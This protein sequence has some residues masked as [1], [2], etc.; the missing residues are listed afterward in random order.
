MRAKAR[1]IGMLTFCIALVAAASARATEEVTD[2]NGKKIHLEE[3]DV[4]SHGL[5]IHYY[6]VGEGPLVFISHGHTAFWMDW[7]NQ[8]SVLSRKYKVVIYDLRNHNKSGAVSGLEN[9][10]NAKLGDDLL[11]LQNHFTRR[12][13]IHIGHD[14][15][16]MV[17]W[18]YAMDHPDKVSLL[19]EE[20]AI[21]PR[22]FG[23]ALATDS[24]QQKASWYIQ[25]MHEDPPAAYQRA[26]RGFSPD[27][28]SR[29]SQTAEIR[30][31]WGDA[32]RRTS[33]V[34]FAG[35][36]D[37]YRANF[38]A[39]PYRLDSEIFGRRGEEFP[40]VKAPTLVIQS[41]EDVA[42]MSRSVDGVGSWVDADFTLVTLPG[43]GH[44]VH[45]EQPEKI[46]GLIMNWLDFH[47]AGVARDRR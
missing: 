12:A 26:K 10:T 27:V 36:V 6:T 41:L 19:I 46:N 16:G 17:L 38:P 28:P 14:M 22:A 7:R 5:N 18:G 13:A 23:R 15:G 43:Q 37:W 24:E 40:H 4:R 21:H 33:D 47:L 34:A 9:N 3:G 30:Q 25:V 39:K 35:N 29:Q 2:W 31:L 20:N 44:N 42:L 8:L 11:A 1:R 45:V 32:Y